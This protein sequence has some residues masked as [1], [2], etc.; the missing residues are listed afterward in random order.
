MSPSPPKVT[1]ALLVA[2]ALAVTGCG[3]GDPVTVKRDGAQ[4][5][6][7][8]GAFTDPDLGISFVRPAGWSV[9]RPRGVLRVISRDREALVAVSA[10]PGRRSLRAVLAS[11]VKALRASYRD[12]RVLG[13]SSRKV[14]GRPAF[15]ALLTGRHRRGGGR[16]RILSN[17]VAGRTQAYLIQIFSAS[18]APARRLV[19]AQVLLSSLKLKR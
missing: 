11:A 15:N 3:G 6:K 16:L 13:R 19:E 12:V 8:S 4:L 5:P 9:S 10:L 7:T 2:A 17:A 18:P 1:A 14:A